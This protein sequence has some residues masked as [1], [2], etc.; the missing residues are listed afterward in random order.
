MKGNVTFVNSEG[1][2]ENPNKLIQRLA[3]LIFV[4]KKIT[5]KIENKD[6]IKT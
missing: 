1:C 5:Y 6:T 4:S 3:P 2:N